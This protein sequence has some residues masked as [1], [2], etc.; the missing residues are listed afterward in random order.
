MSLRIRVKEVVGKLTK[1]EKEQHKDL[2]KECEERE[3]MLDESE[4]TLQQYDKAVF[5][6]IRNCDEFF[7][8]LK[9]LQKTSRTKF[10]L[11]SAQGKWLC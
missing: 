7:Q 3:K 6:F 9:S 5:Q 1:E 8:T 4:I 11:P 2:I 10:I